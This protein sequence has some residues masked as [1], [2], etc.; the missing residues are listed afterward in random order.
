MAEEKTDNFV[1]AVSIAA[2]RFPL[3]QNPERTNVSIRREG[4]RL[5][6]VHWSCYI[7]K[8]LLLFNFCFCFYSDRTDVQIA[9]PFIK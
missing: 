6:T 5:C 3:P 4:G 2:T 8:L 1:F 7:K 9:T